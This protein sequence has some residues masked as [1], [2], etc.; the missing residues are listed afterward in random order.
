[1]R[2][3][4]VDVNFDYK[5]IIY[6]QFYNYL[7]YNNEVDFFGPGYVTRDTLENGILEFIDKG[8]YD[9]LIL[10]VYFVYSANID[11]MHYNAYSVHRNV[12]PYYKVNDAYVCCHN[13]YEQLKVIN[14]I[15]KIFYYYEDTALSSAGD[16]R[17][18]EELIQSGFYLMGDPPQ[19]MSRYSQ[20]KLEKHPLLTN[21]MLELIV[22]NEEYYIPL[23][24]LAI[25]YHEIFH[26]CYTSRE[27][28]WCVPGN[29]AKKYYPMREVIYNE[30]YEK[31]YKCW[32]DDQYKELSVNSIEKK[33]MERYVFRNIEERLLSR[34]LGKNNYICS[35][36]KIDYVAACREQYLE[37]MRNTR[38]VFTDG[39]IMEVLVRKYFE[40][41]ACGALLVGM[42]VA[43]LEAFGF[44]DG[45]NCRIVNE[46]N[47]EAVIKDIMKDN[48]NNE[49][50]A[51]RGQKLILGKHMF[52][53]RAIS[54]VQTID[55]IRNKCYKGAYWYEGDYI[56]KKC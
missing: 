37:S 23:T 30:L 56:I 19:I 44:R 16:C 15:I 21:S 32:S 9:A 35:Y 28:E 40:A 5:N 34:I 14:G 38:A 43:G 8:K 51:A 31:G 52:T 1:M 7:S 48:C 13:I 26:N 3:L 10:G 29:R 42:K 2:L 39:G 33:R 4:I 41:C 24:C 55:A 20:A 27:Y 50:I 53:N 47:R 36:P 17:V 12:I 18:C 45:Y 49:K 25:S 22:R 11:G 6:R 54:F 46:E